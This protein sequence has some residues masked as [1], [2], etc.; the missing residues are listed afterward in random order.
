M[1]DFV[2]SGPIGFSGSYPGSVYSFVSE[3]GGSITSAGG[4]SLSDLFSDANA[5]GITLSGSASYSAPHGMSEFDGMSYTSEPSNT[6]GGGAD[7]NTYLAADSSSPSRWYQKAFGFKVDIN[8]EGDKIVVGGTRTIGDDDSPKYSSSSYEDKMVTWLF[9]NDPVGSDTWLDYSYAGTK[10][11]YPNTVEG[12]NEPMGAVCV[13]APAGHPDDVIGTVVVGAYSNLKL[14]YPYARGNERHMFALS[15]WSGD[16]AGGSTWVWRYSQGSDYCYYGGSDIALSEGGTVM[17]QG[18]DS[19]NYPNYNDDVGSRVYAFMLSGWWKPGFPTPST[20]NYWQSIPRNTTYNS[21]STTTAITPWNS[22]YE[23][24]FGRSVAVNACTGNEQAII[25]VGAPSYPSVSMAHNGFVQAFQY[26]WGPLD[27]ETYFRSGSWVQMGST[28]NGTSSMDFAGVSVA[29]NNA[30][31]MLVVGCPNTPPE[32]DPS[33][34]GCARVYG[35]DMATPN[36]WAQIG[37]DIVGH[38]GIDNSGEFGMKVAMNGSGNVILVACED[39]T[40]YYNHSLA[41]EISAG[42]AVY[43]YLLSGGQYEQFG[44]PIL[45]SYDQTGVQGYWS[46]RGAKFGH[47]VALNKAGDKAVVGAPFWD[48]ENNT[49]VYGL[50]E[51]FSI[52]GLP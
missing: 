25:A 14:S 15:T 49:S 33:S 3:A 38:D 43:A 16:G 34:L 51:T 45:C 23:T 2:T 30:G 29:L 26:T 52:G 1:A 46:M 24:E 50:V 41:G 5:A 27:T 48:E 9:Y 19:V 47:D 17:V 37:P 28:I 7:S 12:T 11:R 42:G 13:S 22:N 8:A 20:L 10:I 18:C 31:N 44:P 39:C 40:G 32:D 6:G 21:A 36:D 4:I 35:Y